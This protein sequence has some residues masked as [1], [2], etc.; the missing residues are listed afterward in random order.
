MGGNESSSWRN[1][2]FRSSYDSSPTKE[3]TSQNSAIESRHL[4]FPKGIFC[5]STRLWLRKEMPRS[6]RRWFGICDDHNHKYASWNIWAELW[7]HIQYDTH[8]IGRYKSFE[9]ILAFFLLKNICLLQ[10]QQYPI[11]AIAGHWT[12][13]L[14]FLA[15]AISKS[16]GAVQHFL[17]SLLLSLTHSYPLSLTAL[18]HPLNYRKAFC[19]AHG[20]SPHLLNTVA[21]GMKDPRFTYHNPRTK[22][23]PRMSMEDMKTLG[24]N[25]G[26]TLDEDQI[27][28]S[29]MPDSPESFLC[30][31]WMADYFSKSGDH[32]PNSD[33]EVKLPRF[34][35]CSRPYSCSCSHPHSR[36]IL[37]A[38]LSSPLSPH[39]YASFFPFHITLCVIS[40]LNSDSFG[41]DRKKDSTRHILC[42]HGDWLP[43]ISGLLLLKIPWTLENLVSKGVDSSLQGS[44]RQVP[45]LC[46]TY[47]FARDM[48]R[49]DH[50]KNHSRF[51]CSSSINLY[52]RTTNVSS[53]SAS[54]PAECFS[55]PQILQPDYPRR[56]RSRQRHVLHYGWN[57]PKSLFNSVGSK[58]AQFWEATQAAFARSLGAP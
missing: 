2:V 44:H 40:L 5:D 8:Q 17:F 1:S 51:F 13:R 12:F 56:A 46:S 45:N 36:P 53:P 24:K 23:R 21:K 52:G 42:R 7:G 34:C 3:K 55:F 54:H 27:R 22:E 48:R 37:L 32:I 19:L 58:S 35:P 50:K 20:I 11:I 26:L 41:L 16:A 6:T 39:A 31:I 28:A 33:G 38:P 14:V 49:Q 9:R 43:S 57:G 18:I 30:N 15:G 25:Y 4:R 10:L 47:W 29:I